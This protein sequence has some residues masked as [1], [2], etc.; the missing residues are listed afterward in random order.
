MWQ[1]AAEQKINADT[2]RL[3]AETQL[4][5]FTLFLED[6]NHNIILQKRGFKNVNKINFQLIELDE[7][8]YSRES[9]FHLANSDNKK[10]YRLITCFAAI[11]NEINS[12]CKEADYLFIKFLSNKEMADKPLNSASLVGLLKPLQQTQFFVVRVREVLNLALKQLCIVLDKKSGNT[13]KFHNMFNSLG[14]L[15]ICLLKFDYLLESPILKQQWLMYIKM[16]KNA[17]H[18][19]Q[20]NKNKLIA[21]NKTLLLIETQLLMGTILKETIEQCLENKD[22]YL[23]M[24]SCTLN[25]ELLSYVDLLLTELESSENLKIE[26]WWK[27][28]IF[29][30]FQNNI[31]G[32]IDKKVIKRA[33]E[34]NKKRSSCTVIGSYI[35]YPEQFL[36][37]HAISLEKHIDEKTIE[38][39]RLNQITV[40]SKGFHK[41]INPLCHQACCLL[42]EIE[43]VLKLTTASLKSKELQIAVQ[44]IGEAMKLLDKI[45]FLLKWVLN[46]KTDKK[47]SITKTEIL[48]ACKLIEVLKCFSFF[49]LGNK[50][51][52]SNIV[53]V[54]TQH[55][56]YKALT[57]LHSIKKHTTQ[58]KSYKEHQL[59][60]LSAFNICEQALK[61]CCTPQ[62]LLVANLALSACGGNSSLSE[63][64]STLH[65]LETVMNF[66]KLLKSSSNCAFLYWHQS[67]MLP[68]YFQKVLS[69]KTD[70]SRYHLIVNALN[71]CLEV[72]REKTTKIMNK[73][74]TDE[75]YKAFAQVIEGNLRLQTHL[76]LHLPPIDPFENYYS[77]NL[78]KDN[79]V[80]L[81]NLYKS[82]KNEIEH[83]LSETFYNLTSVVL[84]DWKTYG[85]MRKLASLEYNLDTVDDTLPMQTLEQGLDVLEIMRN[86]NIFVSKYNYNLNSQVFI[87][88]A[89][90]NKHLNSIGISHVAN[91]IRTH[92]VG[93]MNTTVN[94]VYQYL[95]N[96]F[97]IF[98]QFI[99]DEHI[100]SRLIKDIRYF[101]E[102]RTTFNQMYPYERAEKFNIGIKKL[103]LN[104]KGESYLDL[105]REVITQIGNAMGYVRL[106][107]SGGRRCLAEGTCFIPELKRVE[108]LA[109]TI[110]SYDI[111]DLSKKAVTNV[112]DN[113]NTYLDNMKDST[114][115]FSLL[116]RVFEPVL[117]DSN[118][119]HLKNFFVIIPPLTINF[120]EHSLNCKE[121]LNKRYNEYTFTDDGFALGLAYVI[122]LLNQ[123]KKFDS[124]HWFH[125]VHKKLQNDRNKISEQMNN[126]DTQETKLM[127]TLTLT[128]KKISMY[129]NEFKLLYYSYNSARLFFQN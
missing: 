116:V 21:F 56:S 82:M 45:N 81:G 9:I 50:I 32:S 85:E 112:L 4:H 49:L 71:D 52:F 58:E 128:N 42:L 101:S 94:F 2:H 14:D 105:F 68:I 7:Q 61:K 109:D 84:H 37:K 26:V 34:I 106:I 73:M 43:K 22:L 10:L 33:L 59:D 17:T 66:S 99:F 39:F 118:N 114:E 6:V 44:L 57:M 70:Y 95:R 92:G 75:F 20:F 55:L 64:R 124:L 47:M 35:W 25:N 97:H 41:D 104:Q 36:L 126:A 13:W 76:H 67:Y 123:E 125:S 60:V 111:P 86:I 51:K 65:Q 91:S 83:H 80:L 102:G 69:S 120:V 90:N 78:E 5:K 79:P 28:N 93:I 103:G 1:V 8:L 48:A 121:K 31:F 74:I 15:F 110:E 117:R 12:L 115:Y 19:K 18:S 72:N 129:E 119:L 46:L 107:R 16:I 88:K 54:V 30:V 98:S 108:T 89:S 40:K 23:K 77:L 3:I 113:L 29:L 53:L 11:C 122:E 27:M 96:Q 62:S 127:Q 100:K 38:S 24:K 63:I 87:E